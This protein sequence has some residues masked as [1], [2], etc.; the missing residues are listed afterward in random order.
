MLT[1]FN[2]I[3]HTIIHLRFIQIYHQVYYKLRG[4]LMAPHKFAKPEGYEPVNHLLNFDEKAYQYVPN[5]TKIEFKG[6][7][8]E[9]TF[10]N[11]PHSFK[12]TSLDWNFEGKG[13]LW[14]YNLNYFDFLFS[15]QLSSTQGHEL[16]QDYCNKFSGILGGNEPYP[17]SLRGINWIKFFSRTGLL[18]DELNKALYRQY[19]VLRANVEY[20]IMANHLIENGFSLLFAGYYFQNE[21]FYRKASEILTTELDEQIL[22]DGAHF[23]RSPMYHQI[24]LFRV[25]DCISLVKNN[26]WKN[27]ELLSVLVAKA[28]EMLFWMNEVTFSNGDIPMVKDSAFGIAPDTAWLNDYANRLNIHPSLKTKK[29]GASGFRK[30]KLKGMELF[31]DV[32]HITPTYQPGHAHADETNFILYSNG[33][34]IIVDVGVSTYEKDEKRQRERS[35]ISHN[36]VSI[37]SQN[38]SE[39]WGGFR[40][41]QRAKVSLMEDS[42]SVVRAAHNGYKRYG[43]TVIREFEALDNGISIRDFLKSK[44]DDLKNANLSLHF[45][46][47]VE[48]KLSN[49]EVFID[50]LHITLE[51][52]AGMTIESY[53]FASGFNKLKKAKRIK[54]KM[55]S[56]TRILIN[57]AD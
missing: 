31:A 51:G 52:F 14:N 29:L 57:Y 41:A 26:T 6:A 10:L 34:P 24:M 27:Q 36:C 5:A 30:F 17:I 44:S 33:V 8:A 23:E 49:N 55:A 22:S 13:K 1:K 7:D 37:N 15:A 56:E 11:V 20:H 35:T 53:M 45:H 38:S 2:L 9:F 46:P 32:G 48:L 25:L 16:I 3:F 18:N 12:E 21:G 28:E 50:N 43:V 47:N 4:K 19:K 42:T 39:V 40:V 54:L